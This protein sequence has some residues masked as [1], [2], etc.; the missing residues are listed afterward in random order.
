M[1]VV[2]FLLL[3]YP[4]LPSSKSTLLDED[5]VVPQTDAGGNITTASLVADV[6]AVLI[7]LEGT[8][9]NG[10]EQLGKF[11]ESFGGL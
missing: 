9:A 2:D 3:F 1:G 10:G 4:L 5:L 11:I 6:V 7:L 8:F